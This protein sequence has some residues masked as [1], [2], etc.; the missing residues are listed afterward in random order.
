MDRTISLVALIPAMI[1][2]TPAAA[3]A[4]SSTN[5]TTI[6]ETAPVTDASLEIA[7]AP[8]PRTVRIA[9]RTVA[10][11]SLPSSDDAKAAPEPGAPKRNARR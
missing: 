8:K 10:V 1:V 5:P 4:V 2:V 7:E 6:S 11:D 9:G 3:Q